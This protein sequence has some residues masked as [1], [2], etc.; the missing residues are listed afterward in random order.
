MT[1]SNIKLECF[2]I[3]GGEESSPP[4]ADY[5]R[6]FEAGLLQAKNSITAT[7]EQS[8]SE[9][10][11]TLGDMTFGYTEARDILLE[12]IQPLLAQ[13]SQIVLPQIAMHSFSEHLT[14]AM[15]QAFSDATDKAIE[16]AVEP[17]IIGSL[18]LRNEAVRIVPD[19]A[20][21]HGQARLRRKDTHII[22]DLPALLDALQTALLG[23][24]LTQRTHSNG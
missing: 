12:Q 20:M 18:N 13:I 19:P 8:I 4:S 15:A 17:S 14:E 22:V 9:I 6:G 10:A 23:H 1:F 16:V 2:D 24:D 7:Q 21:E 5:N 11:A 3:D